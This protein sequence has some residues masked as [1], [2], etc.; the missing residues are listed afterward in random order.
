MYH[1]PFV[2]ARRGPMPA[3]SSKPMTKGV[4]YEGGDGSSI[5]DGVSPDKRCA[6]LTISDPRSAKSQMSTCPSFRPATVAAFANDS[7]LGLAMS[8]RSR[9]LRGR[10]PGSSAPAATVRGCDVSV[11]ESL[12]SGAKGSPCAGAGGISPAVNRVETSRLNAS[13]S[14]TRSLSAYVL[15]RMRSPAQSACVAAAAVAS[16]SVTSARHPRCVSSPSGVSS[17]ASTRERGTSHG[18]IAASSI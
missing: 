17:G 3:L 12:R 11:Q 10:S 15:Y 1:V 2:L 6:T 5:V 8:A 13:I 7:S 14:S 9:S 4:A 18:C 16:S